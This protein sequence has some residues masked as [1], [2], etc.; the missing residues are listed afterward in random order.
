MICF[1]CLINVGEIG[2]LLLKFVIYMIFLCSFH[3]ILA[4]DEVMVEVISFGVRSSFFNYISVRYKY[5]MK[6]FVD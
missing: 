1:L 6:N 3:V 2:N 4:L 5:L